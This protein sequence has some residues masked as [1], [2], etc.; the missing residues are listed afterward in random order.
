MPLK[1][2]SDQQAKS[3]QNLFFTLALFD[4]ID[5]QFSQLAEDIDKDPRTHYLY[6]IFDSLSSAGSMYRWLCT[7]YLSSNDPDAIHNAMMTPGSIMAIIGET[8]FLILF[9]V[10]AYKFDNEE[11][12]EQQAAYKKYIIVGWMY[13]RDIMK[14]LKNVYKGWSSAIIV[15]SLL[16]G[17]LNLSYLIT[18]IGLALGVF[19]A[20][21]RIWLR[22]MLE[23]RKAMMQANIKLTEKIKNLGSLTQLKKEEYLNDIL[24]QSIYKRVLAYLSVGIGG[25][26]DGLY[27]Y[28]GV[29]CLVVITSPIFPVLTG[30]CALYTLACVTT[31]IY[32]EYEFQ[33]RL[34]VTQNK[35]KLELLALDLKCRYS[36]FLALLQKEDKDEAD[37]LELTK[38]KNALRNTLTEFDA[39][40]ILLK[41][42]STH[43][44][45]TAFL[46]G[47]RN[48]L[49]AY[50]ALA[51]VLFAISAIL[52]L[53]GSSF[54]PALLI[55]SVFIGVALLIG[56]I[57]HS[58]ITNYARI[59]VARE[60]DSIERPY[61][62]LVNLNHELQI[63]LE[64]PAVVL[65]QTIFNKCIKDGLDINPHPLS[66]AQE[67]FEI[68]RSL[69]AGFGK[70][71]NF[72]EFAGNPLLEADDL[73]HV[74]DS[75]FLRLIALI[76]S[77]IFG[78]I[79]AIRALAKGLGR[80]PLGQQK[81]T[82]IPPTP[83]HSA[84]NPPYQKTNKDESNL[85]AQSTLSTEDLR[86]NHSTLLSKELDKPAPETSSGRCLPRISSLLPFSIFNSTAK[87][88]TETP[89][90][91]N[92]N[93][94]AA[95]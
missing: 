94:V 78:I 58:L 2:D 38:L 33:R 51:S 31:R 95:L 86:K 59:K 64:V 52:I 11:N 91:Q 5:A 12:K 18:P 14:G 15:A 7:L 6:A 45:F 50:G 82:S 77:A 9:S 79:L 28:V 29:L 20:G 72:A 76:C 46:L 47:L 48:G 84:A 69:F 10:L 74:H 35:C 73:G 44:Q 54:P 32:E 26:L 34:F 40:R 36:E 55:V 17:G 63:E 70:G 43:T 90:S 67:W 68:I 87:S 85:N 27:L 49:Y 1:N 65:D 19:A 21:N 61:N 89:S 39:L 30:I 71:K 75:N 25:F 80:V 8:L 93:T 66:L 16:G 37:L 56:F 92:S 53:A 81:T 88:S 4:Y 60:Q 42:Q 62:E 41:K 22:W 13:F 3:S 57:T 24:Y 83:K 23:D